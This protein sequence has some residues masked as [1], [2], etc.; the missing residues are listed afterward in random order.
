MGNFSKKRRKVKKTKGILEYWLQCSLLA[1]AVSPLAIFVA[2]FVLI[3]TLDPYFYFLQE[4]FPV[5]LTRHSFICGICRFLVTLIKVFSFARLSIPVVLFGNYMICFLSKKTFAKFLKTKM[6]TDT[7]LKIYRTV[8]VLFAT[9]ESFLN[10]IVPI[11][12]TFWEY[13]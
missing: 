11:Y 6:R 13:P 9:T 7:L 2:M 10:P 5:F 3:L 4:F 12:A 8:A 1:L